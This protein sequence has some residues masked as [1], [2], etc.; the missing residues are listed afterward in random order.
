MVYIL[1]PFVCDI[2]ADDD[3]DDDDDWWISLAS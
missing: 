1:V 2:K 3:D